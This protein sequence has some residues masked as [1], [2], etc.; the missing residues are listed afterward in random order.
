L[1]AIWIFTVNKES[2]TVENILEVIPSILTYDGPVLAFLL[3]LSVI[4]SRRLVAFDRFH[5]ELDGVRVALTKRQGWSE[6]ALEMTLN[7]LDEVR[8]SIQEQSKVLA[9]VRA[10]ATI[11]EHLDVIEKVVLVSEQLEKLK[12]SV[13]LAFQE[14]ID[15]DGSIRQDRTRETHGHFKVHIEQTRRNLEK[16]LREKMSLH[17]AE[18]ELEEVLGNMVNPLRHALLSISKQNLDGLQ[19][20]SKRSEEDSERNLRQALARIGTIIDELRSKY[21]EAPLLLA[22]NQ[23]TP[24]EPEKPL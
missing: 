19:S 16:S 13:E 6:K 8:A 9:R 15:R 10:S 4:G 22:G 12:Y 5:D 2:M 17:L 1:I 20:F 23:E 11:S 24:R 18:K 3:L 7:R 21:D 14:A